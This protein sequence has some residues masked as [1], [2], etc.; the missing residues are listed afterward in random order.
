MLQAMSVAIDYEHKMVLWRSIPPLLK[1]LEETHMLGRPVHQ[2][3]S[4]K[5]QRRLASTVPPKPMVEK[6]FNKAVCILD[7]ICRD[8]QEALK[9]IQFGPNNVQA[10]KA[11]L[12]SF[13]SRKPEPWTYPRACLATPLFTCD[14]AGFEQL[15]RKDLEDM[16]LPASVALDPVNWTIEAPQSEASATN[17]QFQLAKTIDHFTQL[18]LRMPGGYVDY[19][20]ALTSN[21]CRVRRSLTHIMSALDEVQ[22]RET[23]QLDT[24]IHRFSTDQI[25]YPLSTWTYLQKLRIM[26]WIVQLG[27]ELDIYLH[28]ELAGMYWYLSFLASSRASL[29]EVI[30]AAI[31]TQ[32]L[33]PQGTQVDETSKAAQ[34]K[35]SLQML[36]SLG[37]EARGTAALAAGLSSL[38]VALAYLGAISDTSTNSPFHQPKSRYELRM[39]P[40]L[41]I[42]SPELPSFK[43]FD[44]ALHPFGKHSPPSGAFA[45]AL[46]AY[47]ETIDGQIKAAK[48]HFAAMKKLGAAASGCQGLEGL[49]A[50]VSDP[51]ESTM[52]SLMLVSQN[53][54]IL[55]QSCIASGIACTV[56]RTSTHGQRPR[57]VIPPSGP[58][59]YHWWIVPKITQLP[60]E[61]LKARHDHH[62]G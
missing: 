13:S 22:M 57:V 45:T 5:I 3:F 26:E 43:D 30:R 42:K 8:C 52:I 37:A 19:F 25:R 55:L 62:V 53:M 32:T 6:T 56:L 14:D 61:A 48:T 16:V 49:W 20:R 21:R 15:L 27:F 12:W 60:E 18:M 34:V 41:T 46:P 35:T 10:L 54:S 11:F 24:A 36:Q 39:K 9:I 59:R 28:D 29:V 33:G 47:F 4:P 44:N 31:D 17:K 50:K 38:Y 23:E 7:Q 1:P 51:L 40:Y 58:D 2:S